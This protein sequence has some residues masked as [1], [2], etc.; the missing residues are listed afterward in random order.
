MANAAVKE[1]YSELYRKY[2]HKIVL[3]AWAATVK[4]VIQ[5]MH[6]NWSPRMTIQQALDS[7]DDFFDPFESL[8]KAKEEFF[9]TVNKL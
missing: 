4:D 7:L 6:D 2:N 5:N 1:K 8:I 3:K 9:Y